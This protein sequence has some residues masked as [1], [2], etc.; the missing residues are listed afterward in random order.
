MNGYNV[1][2]GREYGSLTSSFRPTR[3]AS[4]MTVTVEPVGICVDVETVKAGLPD[5]G[6]TSDN[7]IRLIIEGVTAQIELFLGRDLLTRTRKAMFYAPTSNVYLTPV[8]VAS[9]TSVSTLDDENT[10]TALTLNT[11]YYLRGYKDNLEIY[12]LN[13]NGGVRLEIVY[14]TGYGTA[15]QVPAAIRQAIVQ[16]SY[17]QFKYRQ[18]PADGAAA[19]V[20]TLAPETIA[21]IRSY[22]VRRP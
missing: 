13:L 9:I 8:P 15:S 21:L 10:A 3:Y 14:V 7:L 11:D 4:D 22:I 19:T 17:R 6:A 18:N 2:G 5:Y 20:G 16:E 1:I 12:D